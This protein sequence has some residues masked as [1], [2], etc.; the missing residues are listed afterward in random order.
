MKEALREFDVDALVG[1]DFLVGVDEAGRG[2]LAGPVVAGAVCTGNSFY[3]STCGRW[4]YG[5]I[6]D[7]KKLTP[8]RREYLYTEIMALKRE[9]ELLVGV[10]EADVKEIEQENIV[11]AT[12]L[13]MRRAVDALALERGRFSGLR[14]REGDRSGLLRGLSRSDGES[15]ENDRRSGPTVR[16]LIDGRPLPAFPY[17]HEGIVR[18]DGK[19]LVIAMA[20]IVAKVHR[21]SLMRRL[22]GEFPLY[23]FAEHKGYGTAKHRAAILE[24]GPSLVH[25]ATFLRKLLAAKEVEMFAQ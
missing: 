21:D 20:S 6:D 25:R 16:L 9:G 12:R 15:S 14:E 2:A 11:G 24:N 7:S 19:S 22:D 17:R 1:C 13:A 18:G 4:Q 10:G 8:G 3:E 23:A 5:R